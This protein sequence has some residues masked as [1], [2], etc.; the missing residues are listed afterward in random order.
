MTRPL[1]QIDDVV[2][3]MN[4][5]EYAEWLAEQ[6]QR[7]ADQAASVRSERNRRLAACDWT[8]LPDAPVDRQEWATYRQ[9]LRDVS[10]QTGFPWNVVW[11]SEPS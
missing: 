1:V 4:D 3:P 5:E 11:P 9:E 2:R 10:S 8:Q 6:P 7:D